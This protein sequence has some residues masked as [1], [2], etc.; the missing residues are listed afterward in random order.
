VKTAERSGF[1]TTIP[2]AED[3]KTFEVEALAASGQVVG[4]SAP[5]TSRG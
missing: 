5:F 2:L 4:K 3:Y 1:E